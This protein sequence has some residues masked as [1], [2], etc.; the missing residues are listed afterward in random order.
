MTGED[1]GEN[2][3]GLVGLNNP[4]AV[5]NNSYS[6]TAVDVTGAGSFVGGSL[7][8]DAGTISD[9]SAL[10]S[11]TVGSGSIDIGGLVAKVV[12]RLVLVIR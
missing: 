1:S 9:A 11:V 6:R 7:G 8:V 2:V 10:G 12:L 5:I 3:G 4:G